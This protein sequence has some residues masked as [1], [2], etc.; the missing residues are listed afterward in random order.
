MLIIIKRL[1]KDRANKKYRK[2]FTIKAKEFKPIN[3]I[4]CSE[5]N[6][7]RYSS[8]LKKIKTIK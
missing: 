3:F 4:N 5:Q 8:F 6:K 1:Y 7:V 2:Y